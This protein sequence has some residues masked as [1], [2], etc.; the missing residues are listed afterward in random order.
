MKDRRRGW[1]L[2]LLREGRPESYRVDLSRP[3]ALLLVMATVATVALLGVAGSLLWEGSRAN[4][5]VAELEERLQ[6][7]AG[8]RARIAR[9]AR[10]LEGIEISYLQMRRALGGEVAPSE[11]DVVLPPLGTVASVAEVGW[12]SGSEREE[13]WAWP[14]AQRGFVTRSFGF[15]PN[16]TPAGHP[17]L[18]IAVPEGSYVRAIAPGIVSEARLDSVYG[19]YVRIAHQD[20]FSSLYAHN[21]WVF[22]TAGDTVDRL[23]VVAL[24]GNTGS[25]TAPH[26][27]LEVARDGQRVDPLRYVPVGR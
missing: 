22:A 5:R 7:L 11:R 15:G 2:L 14:L 1:T 18:D 24:S 6:L 10:K 3:V 13:T 16:V 20:G 26:L 17:G 23:E 9:L 19:Y 8:E 27:H 25:S 4:R 12:E 21:S